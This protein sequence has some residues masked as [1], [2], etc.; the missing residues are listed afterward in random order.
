MVAEGHLGPLSKAEFCQLSADMFKFYVG[1]KTRELRTK[2]K[3]KW[4]KVRTLLTDVEQYVK[5]EV[6]LCIN[7][8]TGSAV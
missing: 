3:K 1:L 4:F 7:N 6:V 2:N 5:K 8:Q